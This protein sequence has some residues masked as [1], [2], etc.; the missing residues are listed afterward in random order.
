MKDY[1]ED[2][3]LSIECYREPNIVLTLNEILQ[4]QIKK[5]NKHTHLFTSM[6]YK[7]TAYCTS[8]FESLKLSKQA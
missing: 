5:K 8:S 7:V 6:L 4:G 1:M 3:L 2:E